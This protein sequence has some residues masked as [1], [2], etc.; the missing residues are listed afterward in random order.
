MNCPT[1]TESEL[2]FRETNRPTGV[3]VGHPLDE[4]RSSALSIGGV[5][6]L[7]LA[8][9]LVIGTVSP[10]ARSFET[11]NQWL[12]VTSLASPLVVLPLLAFR[13]RTIG[14]LRGGVSWLGLLVAAVLS[15][16]V[17][18]INVALFPPDKNLVTLQAD[19]VAILAVVVIAPIAEEVLLRGVVFESVFRRMGWR[20]AVFITAVGAASAHG[21]FR[22][23]ILIQLGI[24]AV[25]LVS[26][27]SLVMSACCHS[28]FNVQLFFPA[29][30]WSRNLF[31]F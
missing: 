4:I 8:I 1:G 12:F 11:I 15:L 19:P 21:N 23:A 18:N 20:A 31:N 3:R 26:R 16:V 22:A 24:T 10:I 9:H 27:R 14:L 7:F 17:P 25:Y 28:L 5:C 29:F 13:P 30:L 6:G 2:E